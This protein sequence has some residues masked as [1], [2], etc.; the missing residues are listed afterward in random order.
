MASWRVASPSGCTGSSALHWACCSGSINGSAA[1]RRPLATVRR[2]AKLDA[3]RTLARCSPLEALKHRSCTEQ[4]R[5]V[6]AFGEILVDRAK[7]G[8][9]LV[10]AALRLTESRQRGCA[11]QRVQQCSLPLGDLDRP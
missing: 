5:V 3:R 6:E 7:R 10:S 1:S 4:V 9:G 8:T 2:P 11:A